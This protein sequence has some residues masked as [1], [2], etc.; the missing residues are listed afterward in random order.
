MSRREATV[1]PD[2]LLEVRNNAASQIVQFLPTI[3]GDIIIDVSKLID[4]DIEAPLP[5]GGFTSLREQDVANRLK[6]DGP[7][8]KRRREEDSALRFYDSASQIVANFLRGPYQAGWDMPQTVRRRVEEPVSPPEVRPRNISTDSGDSSGS[9]DS[10][11]SDP[12]RATSR[13]TAATSTSPDPPSSRVSRPVTGGDPFG[14]LNAPTNFPAPA[15]PSVAQSAYN[16]RAG[17]N[18]W[19]PRSGTLIANSS[20]P[21]VPLNP[22]LQ[23]EPIYT[24]AYVTFGAGMRQKEVDTF[25]AN[26]QLEARS[27]A[28]PNTT[29]PYHVPLYVSLALFSFHQ[30]I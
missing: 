15:P 4:I 12:E 17:P 10:P 1:L 7:S 8:G 19:G 16:P 13:S 30:P 2:G 22:A 20:L 26:H 6:D 27:L 18:P 24:H 21:P 11:N 14:Y 29:V 5:G 28:G 9:D 23:A 25:T 3:A